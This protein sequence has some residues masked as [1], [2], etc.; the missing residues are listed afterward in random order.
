MWGG[1]TLGAG[2]DKIFLIVGFAASI[3]IKITV[4]TAVAKAAKAGVIFSDG[5]FIILAT[6]QK[7]VFS[8]DVTMFCC[9]FKKTGVGS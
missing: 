5:P 3:S 4:I 2:G 9:T 6:A 8:H 1:G 7:V